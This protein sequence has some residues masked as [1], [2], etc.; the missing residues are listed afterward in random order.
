MCGQENGISY[1]QI[2][3]RNKVISKQIILSVYI[4]ITDS[5]RK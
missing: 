3:I 2:Y 5:N 1:E 4:Y